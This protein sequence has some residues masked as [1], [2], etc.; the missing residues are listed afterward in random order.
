VV[1][2]LLIALLALAVAAPAA[3]A[4]ATLESSTPERGA[5]LDAQP[6]QV[7]FSFN[8]PVEG[9]FGALRV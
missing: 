1:R 9:S 8:E 4:H 6:G 7:A 3:S 2:A 5:A